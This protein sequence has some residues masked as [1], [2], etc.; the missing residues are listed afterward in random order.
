MAKT[1]ESDC[2]DSSTSQCVATAEAAGQVIYL[3]PRLL[4]PV[5]LAPNVVIR[6]ELPAD[7]A[8]LAAADA[9]VAACLVPVAQAGQALRGAGAAAL[10]EARANVA[11]RYLRRK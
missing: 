4:K 11:N 1:K 8:A 9:D 7:L 5:H 2:G 6:G 10:A 3:G